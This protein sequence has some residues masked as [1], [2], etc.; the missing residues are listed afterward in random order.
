MLAT[1]GTTPAPAVDERPISGPRL[2]P[3]TCYA[4]YLKLEA[5]HGLEGVRAAIRQAIA[6]NDQ[7][8]LLF[9]EQRLAEVIG[10]DS[11]A[12]LQVA[13]WADT[14]PEPEMSLYLRAVR[15]TEAVRSPAV[16]DRLANMAESHPDPGHQ[17]SALIALETQHRFE[18]A[19]LERLTTLA[20]KDTLTT[21]VTMHTVR[22]LGRV[23][24][25][26]FQRTG[27]FDPY[28]SR[29]LEVALDSTEPSVRGLA[30]EM[31]TYPDARIEGPLLQQLAKLQR[32]DPDPDVRE[33]AALAMSSGRD[34]RAVLEAFR[35]SFPQEKSECVRWA[36][37]RYAVRAAGA[38]ALPL[39]KEF[40][41]QD[42]RFR[43]DH[44][45]FKALYDAGHVDFNRVFS[46]K[47]NHHRC[48]G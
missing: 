26:D 20:R 45:D 11:Q 30:I 36:I 10:K 38:G 25:N 46:S 43:K 28:M 19:M 44:A 33:M 37:V 15:E 34:T 1:L 41:Q 3:L 48:E 4:G 7:G 35:Q 18:P 21:G 12:A 24:D 47:P 27:R 40:G 9:L 5:P 13:G 14:T 23:M 31:G 17:A 29:L 8:A 16:L 39:L 42:A 22:T 6:R 2:P 32:E